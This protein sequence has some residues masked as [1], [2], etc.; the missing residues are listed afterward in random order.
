[1][2]Q[3]RGAFPDPTSEIAAALTDSPA[4]AQPDSCMFDCFSAGKSDDPVSLKN[5]K[6]WR[7]TEHTYP[8][9]HGAVGRSPAGSNESLC[10]PLLPVQPVRQ[11]ILL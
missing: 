8:A 1:M 4:W 5:I 10:L 11:Q 9:E 6:A 2:G 7:G 3:I